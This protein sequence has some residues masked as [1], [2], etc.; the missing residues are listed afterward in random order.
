ME[1]LAKDYRSEPSQGETPV[2]AATPARRGAV[3]AST[4]FAIALAIV[5]GLIFA[6]LFKMVIFDRKKPERPVDTSV[7][8]TVTSANIR[9]KTEVMSIHVKNIRVPQ[10]Q[11]NRLVE[12]HGGKRPL[13]G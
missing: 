2:T 7:Q 6:W 13:T 5:A 4:V 9:D 3:S 11:F 8:V 1:C 10:E 12:L